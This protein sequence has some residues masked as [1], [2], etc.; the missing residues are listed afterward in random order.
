MTRAVRAARP[1]ET[2]RLAAIWHEAWHDAHAALVPAGLAALRTQAHFAERVEGLRT[3][4]RLLVAGDP[5][6]GFAA[7]DCDELEQLMLAREA[8]GTGAASALAAAACQR[9]AADGHARAWLLCAVGNERARRFYEREG[10]H[11]AAEVVERLP[12]DAASPA[13]PRFDV[14]CWRMK[15]ALRG[16][17][18]S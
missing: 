5:A 10:W 11:V 6:L 7:V 14:P 1:S 9:I 13:A 3:E 16:A 8:R 4:D 12:K 15:R 2:E 17:E 18:R